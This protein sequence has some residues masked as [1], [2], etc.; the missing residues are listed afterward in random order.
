[1]YPLC[2]WSDLFSAEVTPNQASLLSVH[3]RP[4]PHCVLLIIFQDW[5]LLFPVIKYFSKSNSSLPSL[6]KLHIQFY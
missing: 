5:S 6:L 4:V 2:F 3:T 1:M